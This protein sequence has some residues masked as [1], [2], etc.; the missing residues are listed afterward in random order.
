M[1]VCALKLLIF[2]TS[3]RALRYVRRNKNTGGGSHENRSFRRHG[4][5]ALAM[6]S[7][8]AT[9][10]QAEVF[11][12]S[13][14]FAD[15]RVASG[16]VEGTVQAD[17]NTVYIYT[18]DSLVVLGESIVPAVSVARDESTPGIVTF[19]NSY[20]NFFATNPTS[21]FGFGVS[22][23]PSSGEVLAVG[24]PPYGPRDVEAFDPTRWS[25]T[26]GRAV[27]EPATWIMMGFGFAGMGALAYRS[28]RRA[29]VAT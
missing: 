9:S 7:L 16:I 22:F 10:A 18:V 25:F 13:Y 23:E 14:T 3:C 15:G 6:S 24:A 26:E 29:T 28:P 21:S 11:D 5:A 1:V 17:L 19:D 2:T 20:M 12:F 27:S 8:V 4:G